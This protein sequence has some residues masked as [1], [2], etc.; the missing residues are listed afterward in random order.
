MKP[1]VSPIIEALHRILGMRL[2]C[3]SLLPATRNRLFC[4]DHI[5]KLIQGLD[6][7][8][9]RKL[10]GFLHMERLSLNHGQTQSMAKSNCAKSAFMDMLLRARSVRKRRQ[11]SLN[12]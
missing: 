8:R 3:P 4:I 5:H 1:Q 9:I 6:S 12:S 7:F 2:F 11:G 10:L